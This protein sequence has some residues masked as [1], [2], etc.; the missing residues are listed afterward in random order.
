VVQITFKHFKLINLW[1]QVIQL[2]RERERVREREILLNK[3]ERRVTEK[4][5]GEKEFET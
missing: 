4:E 3:R 1:R 2:F 5:R